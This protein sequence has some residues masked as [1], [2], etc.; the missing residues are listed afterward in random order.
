[1]SASARKGRKMTTRG[2]AR[3]RN[4]RDEGFEVEVGW[5]LADLYFEAEVDAKPGVEGQA[6]R[7]MMTRKS[8]RRRDWFFVR[9]L[10]TQERGIDVLANVVLGHNNQEDKL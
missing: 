7:R 5:N 3:E 8:C 1:L 2:E 4:G 10:S 6:G 9:S